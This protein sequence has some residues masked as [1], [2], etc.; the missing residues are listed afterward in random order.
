MLLRRKTWLLVTRL[1]R[2]LPFVLGQPALGGHGRCRALPD[3]RGH[4][5]VDAILHLSGGED[6]LK[7][8]AE[9]QPDLTLMDLRM[10]G[11]G[12]AEATAAIRR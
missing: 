3:G 10:P 1:A 12:G 8:F 2:T 5:A 4:L 6:A 11:L 7:V 9:H